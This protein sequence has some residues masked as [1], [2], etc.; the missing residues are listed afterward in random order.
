VKIN[1]QILAQLTGQFSNAHKSLKGDAFGTRSLFIGTLCA[2]RHNIE[3]L[4]QQRP[5]A[6]AAFERQV[7]NFKRK[8]DQKCHFLL[9]MTFS[10]P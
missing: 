8:Y 2:I 3:E 7:D 4:R 1:L 6:V 5:T 9:M 10:D